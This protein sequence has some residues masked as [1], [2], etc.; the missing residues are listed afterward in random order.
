MSHP[1]LQP[2]DGEEALRLLEQYGALQRGHFLLS[3]GLHSPEYVQC[4]LLLQHPQAT[5]R[6]CAA[7]VRPFRRAGVQV[8]AGPAIGAIPLVY[9]AARQLEARGIWTERVGGQMQ[10]RRS[11]GVA[12]GERVLVVEDVVTTGGSVREVVEAMRQLGAEVVGV[13]ALV[14]RTAGTD[15]GFDVPFLA[16]VRLQLATYDPACCPLCQAGLPLHHP[17]SRSFTNCE[18]SRP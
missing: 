15:P 11:F 4:A 18:R 16:L 2:A 8:V 5:A 10:V 6:V 14:D 13:A 12:R 9:E 1:P 17:G 7:L 3:S